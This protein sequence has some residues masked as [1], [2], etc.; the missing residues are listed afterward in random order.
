MSPPD[1]SY[2]TFLAACG[3]TI[4]DLI[5]ESTEVSVPSVLD[6]G[7]DLEVEY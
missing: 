4:S 3:V 5:E 2:T 6:P 7:F 1:E